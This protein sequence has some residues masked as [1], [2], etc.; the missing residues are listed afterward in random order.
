MRK[1]FFCMFMFLV[2]LF[3]CEEISGQTLL[4]TYQFTG[5]SL[6]SGPP[7]RLIASNVASNVTFSS[8]SKNTLTINAQSASDD[9]VLSVKP[10][11]GNF[12][13]VLN[14][15]SF[16]E[17]TVTPNSGYYLS[18]GSI[19]FLIMKTAAGATNFSVRSSLDS[20]ASDLLTGT[21]STSSSLMTV[22]LTGNSNSA[23]TYRIYFY[24]GSSTGF[25][26]IDDV[27]L[28]GLVNCIPPQTVNI[29]PAA[30]SLCEG[31]ITTLTASGGRSTDLGFVKANSGILSL[32]IPDN[33]PLGALSNLTVSGIPV[34]ATITGVSINFNI[35]HTY[36]P[37]L[38]INL[39]APNTKV[40]N[41]YNKSYDIFAA[42][43]IDFINTTVNSGS[44]TTFDSSL[45][46]YTGTFGADAINSITASSGI[47]SNVVNWSNL[48]TIPN[49]TW[50]LSIKDDTSIDSGILNSWSITINWN[51]I[52]TI[53]PI[54]WLPI[55]GLY[56]NSIA[57]IPY[58]TGSNTTIVYAKPLTSKIYSATAT[59]ATGCTATGTSNITVNPKPT[60]TILGSSTLCS[61]NATTLTATGASSYLWSNSLGINPSINI[62]P[63]TNTQYSVTGTNSNNCTNTATI[64]VTIN[65]NPLTTQ[66]YHQ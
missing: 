21:I 43:Y 2:I 46:P 61:G 19:T 5:T 7:T 36:T 44:S 56:S 25:V 4:G 62:N 9:E 6:T 26:R 39:K 1:G 57:T 32:N 33:S 51:T 24:G 53:N 20:F 64:N 41:I 28:N 42:S 50:T 10:S 40:L 16:E 37:D 15:N 49:G 22:P 8:Y 35:S 38:I 66:I 12:G 14:P 65:Q 58:S 63:T 13:T 11:T 48:Y 54:T 31:G 23:V 3:R 30:A 47:T 59:A 55:D 45:N 17:F 60:V 27:T 29:S 18:L 34:G 52:T